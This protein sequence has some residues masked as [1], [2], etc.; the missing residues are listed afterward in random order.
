MI[1][2]L[3]PL[4]AILFDL[5]GVLLFPKPAPPVN[6]MIG[7]I[8][9]IIGQVTD[10]KAFKARLTHHFWLE[11]ASLDLAM[12]SVA[13]RYTPYQPLW[14]LL[15]ALR[16]RYRLGIIN[17]GTYLTYPYFDAAYAIGRL[18]DVFVSSAIERIKKPDRAIYLHAC[19]KLG[20]S[21]AACLFMDDDQGNVDGARQAGLQAIHW[22]T[23][24]T[25]FEQ[26][27]EFMRQS[28]RSI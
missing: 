18:L 10:D 2:D 28:D 1:S 22:E 8:D 27:I 16:Q 11:G 9:A 12:R 13:E 4:R 25:G 21:P 6:D 23:R 15:P 3:H 24:E 17:N 14:D 7:Q 20:V 19:Q 26:F 5:V